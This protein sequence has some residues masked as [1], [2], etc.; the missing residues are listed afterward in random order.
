MLLDPQQVSIAQ[1]QN[2]L[3]V[4]NIKQSNEL[5][6]PLTII[7]VIASVISG[8]LRILLLWTQTRLAHAIGA[9]ISYKI[10][11]SALHQP[12]S[13]HASRNSSEVIAGITA[14]ADGVT[15]V[16]LPLLTLSST[17][18]IPLIFAMLISIKPLVAISAFVCFGAVYGLIIFITRQRLQFNGWLLSTLVTKRI[19]VLNE[20]LG[21]IRDVILNGTQS[22]YKQLYRDADLPLRYATAVNL[23]ISGSPRY[24]IEAV[25]MILIAGLAYALVS[26]GESIVM[27]FQRWEHW[28][29]VRNGCC[30]C[31]N[32][33]ILA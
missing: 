18:L 16:I 33:D 24:C 5:I 15:G 6:L 2:H 8:G 20:G 23:V 21:G 7:F 32:K 1:L 14:K 11:S 10:Y 29:L 26:N 28:R 4:L 17:L 31:F 19:K 25:G 22:Y 30:Q 13:A 12:Y 9:D 3:L 27:R